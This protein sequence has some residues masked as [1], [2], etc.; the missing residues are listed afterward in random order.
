MALIIAAVLFTGF[1][2]DMILGAFTGN[3]ILSDVQS[4]LVLFAASIAFVTE[5]IRREAQSKK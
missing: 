2:L 4:M 5:I 1:V 3:A